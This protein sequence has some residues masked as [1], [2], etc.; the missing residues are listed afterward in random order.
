MGSIKRV[1]TFS[2]LPVDCIAFVAFHPFLR[3]AYQ[4]APSAVRVPSV[5][6]IWSPHAVM[7]VMGFET[8]FAT[9]NSFCDSGG[10]KSSRQLIIPRRSD[11]HTARGQIKNP[12]RGG[13]G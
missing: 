7:R 6:E 4:A 1:K 3:R 8:G 13:A 9:R 12:A 2:A 10:V 5:P 11:R